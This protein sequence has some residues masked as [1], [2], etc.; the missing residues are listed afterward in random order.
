M[1]RRVIAIILLLIATESRA[2]QSGVDFG[3][4]YALVVGNN[5]YAFLPRLET[6]VSDAA[7]VAELLRS[8][9]GYRDVRLLLNARRA[10]ILR[11]LNR[12]RAELTERDN[13]LIYYAGHG[14]LDPVA[15]EGFWQPVDARE[16]DDTQWIPNSTLTR[17]LKTMS[18]KHVMIVADSCYSG[19]L[20]RSGGSG[21]DVGSERTAWLRRIAAKRTRTALASGGLEPVA[22]SGENGHS[23]FANAFLSALRENEDIIDGQT[24]F[25]KIKRPVVLN[26]RQTPQYSD[27][28]NSAHE[29]GD[30]LFVPVGANVALPE[31]PA[32][33]GGS[34][35]DRAIELAFWESVRGS[36][37]PR[38]LGSYIDR[39]PDGEFVQLARIM[40][41]ELLSR[42]S[43]KTDPAESSES[44]GHVSN[45]D[46]AETAGKLDELERIKAF[47]EAYG[48]LKTVGCTSARL[49]RLR[50]LRKKLTEADLQR[51]GVALKAMLAV[52]APLLK[53]RYCLVQRPTFKPAESLDGARE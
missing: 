33:S 28:R 9:Y 27:I 38:L 26:A 10:E 45:G 30:F 12:L 53:R 3:G 34:V 17:Y 50:D 44:S 20:L 52:V 22:D 49:Q 13:L 42:R 36:N 4:Y 48:E 23:V 31:A 41:E 18:A 46:D 43:R 7:A 14:Y 19:T 29:G 21:P 40:G 1:M 16:D 6:A 5:D 15:S 37:N 35:D 25:Q 11:E 2:D 24:L 51:G 8:R 39:Y 32:G 47:A